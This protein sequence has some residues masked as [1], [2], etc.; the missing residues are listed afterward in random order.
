MAESRAC[1]GHRRGRRARSCCRREGRRLRPRARGRCWGSS[2]DRGLVEGDGDKARS[3]PGWGLGHHPI[4]RPRR[5]STERRCASRPSARASVMAGAARRRQGGGV[6]LQ[7]RRTLHEIEHTEAGGETGAA[8]G[9]E[10]VVGARRRSR[11]S[12]RAYERR[13][14]SRRRCGCGRQA[15]RGRASRSRDARRRCG[16]PAAGPRRAC[17]GR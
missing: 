6:E 15:P 13:G 3:R 7:D 12:P 10:H 8:G 17:A 4:L 14:R 11:R 2:A 9:G 5:I 16:R 1:R